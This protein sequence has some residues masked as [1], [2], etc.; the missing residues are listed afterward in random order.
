MFFLYE[1][2]IVITYLL[3]GYLGFI[4]FIGIAA[5]IFLKNQKKY[6][7]TIID[8][9]ILSLPLHSIS[10]FGTYINHIFSWPIIL[11]TFISFYNINT[12]IKKHIKFSMLSLAL[13]II[14]CVILF[15]S[16]ILMGDFSIGLI[17][18]CQILLMAIPIITTFLCKN[19]IILE[20]NSDYWEKIIYKIKNVI[21]AVAIGVLIQYI[22]YNLFNI[23]LGN[24]TIFPNREIYDLFFY[25]YSVLSLFLSLG[26]IIL[27]N[28]LLKNFKLIDLLQIFI[29]LIAI[30]LNSSR[31]GLMS[32][33]ITIFIMLNIKIKNIKK[34]QKLFFNIGFLA[35]A[36]GVVF[37]FLLH[38]NELTNFFDNNARF[39]TYGHGLELIFTS[40]KV[41]FLG[42][43]LNTN[44]YIEIL[45]HNLILETWVTCGILFTAIV[46]FAIVYLLYY[47]KNTQYKFLIYD[48]LIGSMFIT[49]FQGNPFTT[50]LCMLAIIDQ[51]I[52]T[53]DKQIKTNSNINSNILENNDSN[54]IKISIIVPVYNVEKY[55][56]ECID[57]LINQT[58]KNI[59]IIL[60]DDGST[61][62]SGKI[63][64]EYAKKDSRIIVIHKKNGGVSNA[65]N[66]G[67]KIASGDYIT[68]VD[69]DDW[70]KTSTFE[71]LVIQIKK[72]Q[73]DIIKFSYIK[74]CGEF[75]KEYKFTTE[76]NKLILK[77]QYEDL[78]YKNIFPTYDLSNSCNCLFKTSVIKNIKFMN[79]TKF[80]EDFMFMID[81]LLVSNSILFINDSYYY[82]RVNMQSAT[83]TI[84]LEKL[85]ETFNHELQITDNIIKKLPNNEKYISQMKDRIISLENQLIK[86][87]SL[88]KYED[89]KSIIKLI[90][91][92]N[93]EL[94][95]TQNF[96]I[97]IFKF[98]T[99]KFKM[100]IINFVKLII[101]F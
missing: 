85:F 83:N 3:N 36:I 92:N 7:E 63:C 90:N 44:N 87:A 17:K 26:I 64:D 100:L 56:S 2:I 31:T 101:T 86:Q 14:S 62:K 47:L 73:P 75:E 66:K 19:E 81:A 71:N 61:D 18:I 29:I 48:I 50:I 45:P 52:I 72:Q 33:I 28:N 67:I 22:F 25:A 57:S 20:V 80:G 35:I 93:K 41:F 55:L 65:R 97:N 98:L 59:E 69:S 37:I 74:K 10:I 30:I 12:I 39:S 58:Y 70:L 21:L 78:I 84:K 99:L 38:R 46:M 16:N 79:K 91:N 76:V 51:K 43:G 13:F 23:N 54:S 95:I 8:L 5:H 89:C 53:K 1:L 34:K 68:F 60:V 96:D 49:C 24:I 32:G 11:L 15:I 88:L 42:N 4:A 6:V 77:K 27:T 40:I 9:L 82:Y 94:E